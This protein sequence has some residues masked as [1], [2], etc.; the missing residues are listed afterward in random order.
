MKRLAIVFP[1]VVLALLAYGLVAAH[2]GRPQEPIPSFAPREPLDLGELRA[3]LG[4]ASLRGRVVDLEGRPVPGVSL[5]FRS[6]DVPFW[7][8]SDARGEFA[9]EGLHDEELA[10]ALLAWGHAPRLERV[11]P[12]T[13]E[14]VL[15]PKTPPIGLVPDVPASDLIGQVVHPLGRAALSEAGYEVVLTPRGEPNE[16]GPAV[17]RRALTDSFGYFVFEDLAHSTYDVRVMP[18]WAEGSFWPDLAAPEF[19]TLDHD[20][21]RADARVLLASGALEGTVSDANAQPIEGALVVLAS[22]DDASHLWV[23]QMT[24]AAGRYRFD[25]VPP[26]DYRVSTRAG[27]GAAL[28]LPV[29]IERAAV[30]RL[31]LT[32]LA[33]RER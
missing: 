8:E 17:E 16:L 9:F 33:V 23:P 13:V 21:P 22:P 26:G 4:E 27:E 12:G 11:A 14:F 20:G 19:A 10:V 1:L 5:Y 15:P 7:A 28:D 32:G 25:D 18:A 24:D 31:D 29:T 6:G 30:R 2:L 3:P